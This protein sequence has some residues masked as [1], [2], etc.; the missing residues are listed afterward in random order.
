MTVFRSFTCCWCWGMEVC[1]QWKVVSQPLCGKKESGVPPCAALPGC[2]S[3]CAFPL[4]CPILMLFHSYKAMLTRQNHTVDMHVL[5]AAVQHVL[6][7][8]ID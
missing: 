5:G 4:P 3:T 6:E 8:D 1:S 2:P 7:V